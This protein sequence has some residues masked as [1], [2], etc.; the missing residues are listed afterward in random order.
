MGSSCFGAE[1]RTK[2]LDPMNLIQV[3]LAEGMERNEY[4]TSAVC[5]G[6]F[7][8]KKEEFL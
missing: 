8:S 1:R 7:I 4:K 6:V 3:I 2:V 5:A